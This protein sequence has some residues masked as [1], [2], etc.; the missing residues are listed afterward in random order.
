M[1]RATPRVP[2][3]ARAD[4]LPRPRV[5]VRA[6]RDH[7]R[8][9]DRL[10][11]SGRRRHRHRRAR[12]RR[13]SASPTTGGSS[14]GRASSASGSPSTPASPGPVEE[15]ARVVELLEPDRH[16]PRRQGGLRPAGDGDDPRARHR[17]RDL[18]DVQPQ[19]AGRVGLGR[20]PLDLRHVPA[21]RGPVHD[22]HRRPGD[23][24]DLHPRRAGPARPARASC[25]SRTRR[26][27]PRRRSPRRSSRTS[28]TC[29]RPGSS[30]PRA[31]PWSAKKPDGRRVMPR[32]RVR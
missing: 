17:P 14:G 31:S 2:G 3:Q 20:V 13:P 10:A 11:R 8:E 29:R 9:G 24:Q 19:H 32:G 27:P 7:R 18:P 28:A 26:W 5:P 21:Q 16:R 15:V 25:R 23:A 1:D 4:L 12:S 6:Q 22:Q 30:R